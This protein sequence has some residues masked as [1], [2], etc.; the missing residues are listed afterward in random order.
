MDKDLRGQGKPSSRCGARSGA[1]FLIAFALGIYA[2]YSA[3]MLFKGLVHAQIDV[4]F[5]FEDSGLGTIDLGGHGTTLSGLTEVTLP[6]G[7]LAVETMIF[8]LIAKLSFILTLIGAAIA[9]VP[10]VRSI[11]R[12]DPFAV[13]SIR[14][15]SALSWV[16][17]MGILVYF[18]AGILGSNL[19]SRDLGIADDVGSNT[20]I[21]QTY[22]ILGVL[23][24]IEILRRSFVSGR[25]AQ[26]EL[27]GLV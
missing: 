1:A 2:V 7:D 6:T 3:G 20:S 13:K 15:L 23:G 24:I 26:Q 25:R 22:I 18:V 8:L 10:I 27:E 4:R 16:F 11:G 12:G 17:S 19:A 14:A 5:D 9:F 21:A